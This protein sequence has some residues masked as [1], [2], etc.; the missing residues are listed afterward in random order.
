MG[1]SFDK[2]QIPVDKHRLSLQVQNETQRVAERELR[3]ETKYF[4]VK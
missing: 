2:G 3:V 1:F 4:A